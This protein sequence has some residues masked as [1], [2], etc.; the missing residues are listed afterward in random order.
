MLP[1]NDCW[2]FDGSATLVSYFSGDETPAG[3]ELR[4]E[5]ALVRLCAAAFQAVWD[6]AA[7][8]RQYRS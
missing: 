3:A 8:H 4:D 6:R 5:P 2:L 1:G 7:P